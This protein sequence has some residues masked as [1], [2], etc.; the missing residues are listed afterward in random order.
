M[1]QHGHTETV[2]G[3]LLCISL[4]YIEIEAGLPGDPMNLP[5]H[6]ISWISDRI[7]IDTMLSA[8]DAMGLDIKTDMQG[9]RKWMNNDSFLMTGAAG[10][11]KNTEL[12]ELD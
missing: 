2:T 1:L 9:L 10:L 8:M 3:S 11:L 7:W 4:E 6:E 12:A 5:I